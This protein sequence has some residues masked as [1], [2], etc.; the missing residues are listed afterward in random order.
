MQILASTQWRYSCN[1]HR[2]QGNTCG[3]SKY[4]K[5]NNEA[6]NSFNRKKVPKD[7]FVRR[8]TLGMGV[9]PAV[10]HLNHGVHGMKD[11]CCSLNMKTEISQSFVLKQIQTE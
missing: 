7:V 4:F 9:C 10:I 11:V 5:V 6:L 2:K 1:L 8:D 3:N